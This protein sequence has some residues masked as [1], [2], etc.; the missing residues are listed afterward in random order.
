MIK[1]LALILAT[2]NA[3]TLNLEKK[4]A[5][6]EAKDD[7]YDDWDEWCYD[8]YGMSCDDYWDQW[9]YEYYEMSCDDYWD[10]YCYEYYNMSCDCY[11][12]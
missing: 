3:L 7:Y 11:Y 2:S 6:L 4:L 10:Q 5:E 1:K 9:C 12:D 8:Y